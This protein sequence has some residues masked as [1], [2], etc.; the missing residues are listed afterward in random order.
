M[1]DNDIR[2][3]APVVLD[4]DPAG[5]RH[6]LAGRFGHAAGSFTCT[7]VGGG[8]SNPTY[9]VD[10]AGRQMV[11]R[12][13]PAGPILRGAHAI[14]R[15]F[16]VL[17]ALTQTSVPVPRPILYH[18]DASVVG[19]AFYLMERLFGRVF[20]DCSLPD[21]EPAERRDIY[22]AMAETLARLHALQPE[23]IGLGDFGSRGNY[24]ER[25]IARWSRQ[26]KESPC[27]R[28]AALDELVLWLPRNL[29]AE[30]NR[31]AIAHGDYRLGN[32]IFHPQRPEVIGI[33]D[34]ELSTLGHPLADLGFCCLPWNSTPDEYGG[35]RGLDHA[36]LGIPSQAAFVERYFASAVP[37]PPL[38]RFHIVFALFRF[39]VIFVG[40]ADRARSGSAAS[41]NA[42]ALAPLARRFAERALEII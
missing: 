34:W 21:L 38:Q 4:F 26:W 17:T 29:P 9:F 16:R 6:F 42:A 36:A 32:L 19:T 25:Q 15:E 3:P 23:E 35:I 5:L 8:Q 39:A 24:F 22:F 30:D 31:I 1:T 41:A 37:T 18:E 2:D 13:R 14:D 27:E 20:H 33:L 12:K 7:P 11:L 10:F 28:I 40:I